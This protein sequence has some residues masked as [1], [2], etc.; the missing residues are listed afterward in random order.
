MKTAPAQLRIAPVQTVFPSQARPVN[1]KGELSQPMMILRAYF[2]NK[3]SLLN[4]TLVTLRFA[5]IEI[6]K[7]KTA[8]M[9]RIPFSTTY[10]S[11]KSRQHVDS[12]LNSQSLGSDG[13]YSQRCVEW[14]KK[15]T[16]VNHAMLTPSC[17]AALELAAILS[18]VK[19]GDEVIMPSYTFSSCANAFVL[20]GATP[21][22]VDIDAETFNIDP[23]AVEAAWSP[24]TKAVLA[25][26]YAGMSCDLDAL[27]TIIKSKGAHLIE[28]C[29][30]AIG[31]TYK[32]KPLG[33]FGSMSALSFHYTKNI[34]AGEGGALMINDENLLGRAD[35]IREKGTNRKQFLN[36]LVDKYTWVD[37]GSSYLP[38]E[39]A[40]AFLLGQ[41]E[42][43]ELINN[44]RLQ[45]WTLYHDCLADFEKQGFLR[46]PVVPS[47]AKHNAHMYAILLNDAKS[48]LALQQHL[49]ALD[50]HAHPHYVP[51]H[52]SPFGKKI[53]RTSGSM[54][55]TDDLSAR[56]L[57][58][59]MY[60]GVDKDVS[61]VVDCMRQ[62]MRKS[63]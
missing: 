31:S 29:A 33:S 54:K 61:R 13:S 63:A 18:D 24:K 56:L 41:L 2:D 48:A 39:L 22:F 27:L 32:N 40:S 43:C 45:A 9:T 46:R 50:I 53:G 21:V 35:I 28:D 36:G 16:L 19:A 11:P 30:Q 5:I 52:S 25:V 34:I 7:P 57:R 4:A 3:V 14:I 37:V 20:R 6:T 10:V 49:K 1:N 15:N 26:H 44:Q 60:F 17:T 51:L 58:L 8:L 12:I 59:P 38:S 42:D 47:Y 55:L 23:K 62:F